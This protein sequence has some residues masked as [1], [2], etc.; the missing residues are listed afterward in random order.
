MTKSMNCWSGTI[1]APGFR[2]L[3]VSRALELYDYDVVLVVSKT[4]TTSIE[5]EIAVRIDNRRD[6]FRRVAD[7][8]DAL[9][10]IG[11]MCQW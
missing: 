1:N 10:H 4:T 6:T 5:S 7:V 8:I 3:S 11:R 2:A 9:E